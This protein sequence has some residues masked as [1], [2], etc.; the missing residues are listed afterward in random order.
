MGNTLIGVVI[1]VFLG[2]FAVEVFRRKRPR[3]VKQLEARA[4]RA[5]EAVCAAFREGYSAP[6][7][8]RSRPG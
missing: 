4:A 3:S 5:A 1:G 6:A 7:E 2:A 8:L